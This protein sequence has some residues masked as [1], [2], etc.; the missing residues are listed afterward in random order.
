MAFKRSENSIYPQ[1]YKTFKIKTSDGIDEKEF[2]IQDLTE[3]FF[4]DAVD[5]VVELHGKGAVFH[6]AART[7]N[8][9]KSIEKVRAMYRSVFEQKVS[10]ICLKVD[11]QEIA[12]LNCLGVAERGF[13]KDDVGS[14]NKNQHIRINE[15]NFSRL[16]MMFAS[17]PEQKP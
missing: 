5:M 15:S 2:V 6:H 7:L 16:P 9:E 1:V 4:D 8:D 14:R 3:N 17:K 13:I 10:L 11:T 12:G